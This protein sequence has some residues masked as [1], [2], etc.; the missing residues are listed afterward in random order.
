MIDPRTQRSLRIG[1]LTMRDPRDRRSWSGT[2]YHMARALEKHCGEVINLGPLLPF[3]LRVGN[4]IGRG[5]H[6]LSGRNYLHTHTLALSKKLGAMAEERIL[7]EK[8]DVIF[9]PAAST[10]VAHLRTQTPIVYLSDATVRLMVNY[11]PEFTGLLGSHV[12]AADDLERLSIEKSTCLVYPSSWAADSAVRDYGASPSAV[13][14]VPFGANFESSPSREEALR[15]SRRD[16]CRL[17]FVGV[18][19][20]GKGGDIALE[21]FFALERLGLNPELTV[22]GSRPKKPP[23]HAH[24]KFIPFLNKNEPEARQQ[25]EKLYKEADFFVLPTRAECFGIALCEANAFGLPVVTTRTGGVTEVVREGLNGFLFSL[26]ARGDQYADRIREIYEDSA[27]YDALRASSRGQFDTRLN[28][29]TWGEQ[30]NKI[31]QAAAV[32]SGQVLMAT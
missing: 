9:A 16:R 31:L 28:W 23:D 13:H 3:S 4:L 18:S 30:L 14:I 2:L 12:R 19:W 29:D 7:G 11:N 15:P 20:E 17:L 26:E 25:L 10:I 1:Y 32:D 24:L 8:C 22:V 21:T 6:A 27:A 5:V